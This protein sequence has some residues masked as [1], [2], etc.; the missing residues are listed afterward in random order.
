MMFYQKVRQKKGGLFK[1]EAVNPVR[2]YSGASN[3]AGIILKSNPAAKQRAII[4]NGVNILRVLNDSRKLEAT[5]RI[6]SLLCIELWYQV[7]LS[8]L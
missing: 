6:F 8:K 2:N 7:F 4:S 5:Y 3:L 1:P